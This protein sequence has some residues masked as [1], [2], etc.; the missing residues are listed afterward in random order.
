MLKVTNENYCCSVVKIHHLIDLPGLNNLKGFSCFGQMALV[1]GDVKVGDVV[2]FFGPESKLSH[3]FCHNNNLYRDGSLN[4]DPQKAG[5]FEKGRVKS[6]KLRGHISTAFVCPLSHLSYTGAD[7][8]ILAE[9][10]MFNEINGVEVC[11]KYKVPRQIPQKDSAKAP[12]KDV[13]ID[14]KLMPEH[15]DTAHYLKHDRNLPDD[16]QIVATCKL[17]GVSARFAHQ[18]CKRKLALL[19]KVAKFF[20]C[21]VQETEYDYFAG[22]RRVI[23]DTAKNN[24]H[25]YENDIWNKELEKIKGCIPK[26]W[27]IF[28]EII[29]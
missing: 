29:G 10:N 15:I 28:G 20:G 27:Q 24:V 25:F 17:H 21:K 6:L 1:G 7:L 13:R 5:F 9:G 8:S 22:S 3:D 16:A 19:E 12:K 11:T 26:G 2:L 23:K 14:T 4:K 18:V